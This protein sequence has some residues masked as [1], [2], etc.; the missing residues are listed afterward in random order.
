MR[1]DYS[2]F[3]RRVIVEKATVT[4]DTRGNE[5]RTWTTYHSCYA[6]VKSFDEYV[7]T[8]ERRPDYNTVT[9][10]KIRYC[11]KAAEI[12]PETYRIRYGGTIHRILTATDLNAEHKIVKIKA[13][14]D[15][16]KAAT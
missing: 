1:P 12:V 11:A 8:E 2:E 16:G 13:V 14:V 4:T 15:S 9:E 10:F 6:G 3:D 7:Q 5:V